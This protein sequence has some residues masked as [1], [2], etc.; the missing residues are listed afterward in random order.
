MCRMTELDGFEYT[1][2]KLEV[3]VWKLATGVGGIKERLA[4]AYIELA[5][6]QESDF[7]PELSEEWRQVLFELTKG[8]MQYETVVKNG[9][10]VE[11]PT[12]HLYSTL[13]YMRKSKAQRLAER[14]CVLA[15]KMRSFGP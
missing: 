7:P 2:E 14:I 8:K 9:R 6:L 5:I 10:L 4:D 3:A 1:R 15:A 11:V 13:R 12:G